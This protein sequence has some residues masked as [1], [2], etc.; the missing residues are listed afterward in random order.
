MILGHSIHC[1]TFIANR[2]LQQ[3]ILPPFRQDTEGK[4]CTREVIIRYGEVPCSIF[5]HPGD[6]AVI[7]GL[8]K[9][10]KSNVHL[11]QQDII[12]DE[13]HNTSDDALDATLEVTL[14]KK[15]L[16]NGCQVIVSATNQPTNEMSQM[17]KNYTENL[18]P[19]FIFTY[20]GDKFSNKVRIVYLQPN[21][22]TDTAQ[23]C[24]LSFNLLIASWNISAFALEKEPPH[25][26]CGPPKTSILKKNW[27]FCLLTSY[28][29]SAKEFCLL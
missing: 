18:L 16:Q 28:C 15:I 10:C 3:N 13:S 5:M 27:H 2:I 4:L 8:K 17:L 19:V 22:I 14:K 29:T 9:D 12:I 24:N 25:L 6:Y 11:L 7:E 23:G 21:S 20:K 26:C 1:K